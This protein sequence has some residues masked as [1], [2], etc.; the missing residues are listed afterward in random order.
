MKF[1][2][3]LLCILVIIPLLLATGEAKD[4]APKGLAKYTFELKQFDWITVTT[5]HFRIH[6]L[7][8]SRT[9]HE[10]DA[11]SLLN[12]AIVENHLS[13]LEMDS[14]NEVI[15][16]FYFDSREQIKEVVTKPFRALAD[17]ENLTV[18]AVRNTSETARDAHEI[19]HVISFSVLGGWERRNDID[20]LYEGLATYSDFPCKGYD[21]TEI[22]SHIVQK[23]D[24]LVSL[25]S[26]ALN[27]RKYPEM[28]GYVLMSSFVEYY[29]NNY[30]FDKFI[31][32]WN[33]RY[34][35]MEQILEKEFS[36]IEEEWHRYVIEKYPEPRINNWEGLKAEGCK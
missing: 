35:Q 24:D 13:L 28:I 5:D 9:S 12:E 27:F 25:D 1:C 6:F 2:N 3:K 20:W 36:T 7:P 31:E 26:L 15:D 17:A 33:E 18:L 19:M 10:I 14:F 11:L 30:G 34:I 22:A 16:M 32:I 4:F 23:T 21:M 8:E 29:I